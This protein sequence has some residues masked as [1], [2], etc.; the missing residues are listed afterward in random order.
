MTNEETLS[1]IRFLDN[2]GMR[3]NYYY[4]YQNHRFDKRT[5]EEFLEQVDAEDA[6][7]TAFDLAAAPNTIFGPKYW[8]DLHAKWMKKLQEFRDNG[9]H[10]EPQTVLCEHCGRQLPRSSFAITT[11]GQLHKHCRECESGEWDRRRKEEEAAAKDRERQEKAA[12]VL[13]KEIAEK[14]EKLNKTTKVCGH[15]GKRKLRREFDE[16]GTSTDGLQ[17]WCRECQAE[18]EKASEE[19]EKT[20]SEQEIKYPPKLG[21]HDA[22]LHYKDGNRRIVFNAVLSA[23]VQAAGLT[24]C[25]L[26]TERDGRQ[27]VVFNNSEGA[28]VTIAGTAGR[29]PGLSQVHSVSI[30][31]QIAERFRLA[32]GDLYYLHITKNLSRLKDTINVEVKQV[33]TR[34]EYAAIAARREEEAKRDRA[35]PGEDVPEY[36]VPDAPL[37]DFS[38]E[39]EPEPMPKKA[40]VRTVTAQP[41]RKDTGQTTMIPLANRNPGDLLQQLIDRNHLTED[42]IA[43]F[44]YNKGWKLQKPVVVTTHK[45][46]KI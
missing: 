29:S 15:C 13:E 44:L 8:Q 14:Q 16:S 39:E 22:T 3:Q 19:T 18:A 34:E 21:E 26:S 43:T 23:Q 30:C 25:Y 35:V 5:V 41:A 46:F 12:M 42:D 36:E 11:K 24:K 38:G 20:P 40:D 10:L 1:F 4:F 17:P 45:K 28:N 9:N 6:I 27:F 37:I 2:K 31:R 32:Y 7:L 33:H